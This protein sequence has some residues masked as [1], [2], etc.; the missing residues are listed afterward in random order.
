MNKPPRIINPHRF[1]RLIAWAQAMLAWMALALFSAPAINRRHI[2][3]RYRLLSL[4]RL[5]RFVSAAAIIRATS[6]CPCTGKAGP[7]EGVTPV[8]FPPD[9][10]ALMEGAGQTTGARESALR[11]G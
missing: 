9:R 4:D 2:R 7:L 8:I 3:Q 1:A 5:E 10:E 6:A 11:Q